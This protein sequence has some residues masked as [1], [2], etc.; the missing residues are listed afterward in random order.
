MGNMPTDMRL[1]F[2]GN[3]SQ[4]H[5]TVVELHCVINRSRRSPTALR[6]TALPPPRAANKDADVCT[7]ASMDALVRIQRAGREGGETEM[8]EKVLVVID[9]L[10]VCILRIMWPKRARP[11]NHLIL[12]ISPRCAH[13][14][15]IFELGRLT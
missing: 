13:R 1:F 14:K 3:M 4:Q 8:D 7:C 2:V 12:N 11:I 5:A 6:P 10:G 9:G 15:H